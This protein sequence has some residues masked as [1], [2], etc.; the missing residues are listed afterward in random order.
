MCELNMDA[1]RKCIDRLIELRTG[2]RAYK[3]CH[4]RTDH[5]VIEND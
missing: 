2:G 1:L 3:H 5:G 4:W